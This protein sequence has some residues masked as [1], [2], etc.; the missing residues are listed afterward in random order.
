[1][2]GRASQ[3]QYSVDAVGLQKATAITGLKHKP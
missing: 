2:S 1:M 3:P